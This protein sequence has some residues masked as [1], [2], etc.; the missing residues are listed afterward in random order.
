MKLDSYKWSNHFIQGAEL[1][2]SLYGTIQDLNTAEMELRKNRMIRSII[3]GLDT[4]DF[5]K[6]EIYRG[7][8][9][10]KLPNNAWFLSFVRYR[11]D[12]DKLER[13]LDTV[14]NNDL[15]LFTDEMKRKY[16]YL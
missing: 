1:L 10:D 5:L 9:T 6:P 12:N 3:N 14:Y 11:G 8:F 13:L 15:V 2:D 16:P 7:A 4:I